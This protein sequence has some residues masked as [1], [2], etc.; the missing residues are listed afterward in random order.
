MTMNDK[1]F[2]SVTT[3]FIEA[4]YVI[5]Q[6][7]DISDDDT[8]QRGFSAFI[9]AHKRISE[10]LNAPAES[11]A[12][13]K[14]LPSVNLKPLTDQYKTV[15][16]GYIAFRIAASITNRIGTDAVQAFLG[17]CDRELTRSAKAFGLACY[18]GQLN[19]RTAPTVVVEADEMPRLV[20]SMIYNPESK[21][22]Y[23]SD[24]SE[25]GKVH[26]PFNFQPSDL[27]LLADGNRFCSECKHDIIDVSDMSEDEFLSK[28]RSKLGPA[29]CIFATNLRRRMVTLRSKNE[30]SDLVEPIETLGV[31][32]PP[33]S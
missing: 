1:D 2:P 5:G 15:E 30:L 28:I 26:C 3:E 11:V 32:L 17:L 33:R 20:R 19:R 4:Y 29:P 24:G 6:Y 31:I 18:L 12:S 10:N 25:V 7:T 13:E 8:W 14:V 9:D 16:G 23:G 27:R 21:V 22:L